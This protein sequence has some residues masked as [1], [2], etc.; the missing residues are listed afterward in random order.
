MPFL[1]EFELSTNNLTC[2]AALMMT[3]PMDACTKGCH[4]IQITIGIGLPKPPLVIAIQNL[5][6]NENPVHYYNG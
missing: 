6:S 2:V 1:C 5:A 3:V 4:S